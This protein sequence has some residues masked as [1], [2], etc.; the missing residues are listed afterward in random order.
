M[1]L[2]RSSILLVV[3]LLSVVCAPSAASAATDK[4]AVI[5]NGTVMLGVNASGDL[6]YDCAGAGDTG[7]PDPSLSGAN[8]VGIRWLALNADGTGPG[9]LCEGWGAADAGSGLTGNANQA[10]GGMTNMSVDSFA[11]APDGRSATSTVTISD[12]EIAG[13]K[14]QVVHDYRPSERSANAYRAVVTITNTGTEPLADVRYRRAMDWDVEPTS[15][16]E[17]VTMRGRTPQLLFTS[18]DGFASTDP[19]AEKT[20]LESQIVCGDGY[21]GPCEFTDLGSDGTYTTSDSPGPKTETPEDIGALFDFGFGALAPGE[22]VRFSIFYGAAPDEASAIGTMNAV[23]A[24]IY[25]LGESSCPDD[26]PDGAGEGGDPTGCKDA[27]PNSGVERGTP[28]TFMFGFTTTRADL[29]LTK[30]DQRDPVTVGDSITYTL[31][32][33]NA[34]PD[35]A[36]AV[37]LTDALP[38]GLEFVSATA[39][40]GSCDG[41]STV[42]CNFGTIPVGGS[43]TATIVARTTTAGTVSNTATVTS[44]SE[45]NNAENNTA[46]ATTRVDPPAPP[47]PPPA[48][49]PPASPL[50]ACS[51]K[52]IVLIDVLKQGGRVTLI[53][54]AD[55]SLVGKQVDFIFTATKKRVARAVVAADGTFRARAPMPPRRIRNTSRARYQAVI[56]SQ[57]SDQLKLVRRVVVTSLSSANRKVTIRGQITKPLAKPIAKISVLQRVSCKQTRV[58]KTFKPKR[59]GAFSVTIDAPAG[60]ASAVYI[61][62]TKVRG[63]TKSKKLFLTKSLPRDVLI[64]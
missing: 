58:V 45:D 9:C 24:E 46:T 39:S 23:G 8:P 20:Y 5:S 63:T 25:S 7:C 55:R 31:Q 14:M 44:A 43:A 64:P 29:S 30:T 21:T 50:L 4:G 57:R 10:Q 19:L 6:N 59:S 26:S 13:R 18:D 47:P 34:G 2:R 11:A 17:W 28:V 41:T 15:F 12:P 56:G 62:R 3:C 61:L 36:S 16:E 52:Q 60:Q 49:Q 35:A 48:A 33:Q 1:P 42:T 54:A 32:V 27:A 37:E 38:A 40:S 53:G 51:G 22:R